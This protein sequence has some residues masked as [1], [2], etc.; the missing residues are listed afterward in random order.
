[1]ALIA[2]MFMTSAASARG[3]H[4]IGLVFDGPAPTNAQLRAA[5]EREV[6]TLAG[7]E[8][9][10]SFPKD[11]TL[12]ADWTPE[13]I[14]K[15]LDSL[16][17]DPEVTLV[18]TLG[19]QASYTATQRKDLPKVVYAGGL[20]DVGLPLPQ[21]DGRSGVKNL[22]YLVGSWS[23]TREL[24]LFQSVVPFKR[25]AIVVPEFVVSTMPQALAWGQAQTQDA[26]IELAG[27]V[28]SG[29][30]PEAVIAAL[31]A[32]IEAVYL[33]PLFQM[34]PADRKKLYDALKD[35]KLPTWSR[36]G[37]PEVERGALAGAAPQADLQRRARRIALE[38]Q[39]ML[40]GTPASEIPVRFVEGE[41]LVVNMATARAIGR[42]PSWDVLS[43][44]ELL[45]AR[46][47]KLR[48]LDLSAVMRQ[49]MQRNLDLKVADQQVA[50]GE[51]D[52]ESAKASLLPTVE[53]SALGLMIDRDRARAA[54]GNSPERYI[55]GTISLSQVLYADP[56]WGQYEIQQKLQKQR[57]QSRDQQKLDVALEAGQAF[58]NLLRARTFER[59]QK[60]N[61]RRTRKNLELAEI[62]KE[63][64]SG[65]PGE[66]Y[67]WQSEIAQVKQSALD[68]RA[69]RHLAEIEV[70]RV[71][72][73]DLEDGFEVEETTLEDPRLIISD[74]RVFQFLNDPLS[75]SIFRDFMVE[76]AVKASPELKQLDSLIEA[77]ARS[78]L[79]AERRYYMPTVALQ[80]EL[81][82]RL[83]KGGE[84]AEA[85]IT[86]P[87]DLPIDLSFPT[88][89]ETFWS[90]GV[91]VSLPLYEGGGRSAAVRKAE[92][93][94]MRLKQQRASA[95]L[96]VEQRMRAA[97]QT[98]SASYRGIQLAR[99]AAK[100]AR[101]NFDLVTDAYGRGAANVIQLVDAQNAALVADQ[102]A[103]NAI[104]DFLL[105]YLTAERAVG[106]FSHL[107][108]DAVSR[109]AWL[110]R[111]DAWFRKARA[112]KTPSSSTP[113]QQ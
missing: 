92:A 85:G 89:D 65:N 93:E 71:M 38:T 6:L 102:G 78:E 67:R 25:M 36:F 48:T 72:N 4:R 56:V 87:D 12:T 24:Q 45:N 8:F 32:D 110:D 69:G 91:N 52:V 57:R 111:A 95:K 26:G 64:G 22:A 35:R 30:D 9:E 51:E 31:P 66:V 62:R 18:I 73:H 37:R 46:R 60:E 33:A 83:A 28:P 44:A 58:L 19:F 109:K 23:M 29:T 53:V 97:L 104:F 84:G 55:D 21:K 5:V 49:A 77:Q 41:R 74:Q 108:S 106:S 13:G 7:A 63:V 86:L 79:L 68:A 34:K 20:V 75:F 11:K 17:A 99:D 16:L 10:V 98:V 70:N 39:Q 40:M 100:A 15:A 54:Q 107:E 27:I 80:A 47:P 94:L 2:V 112:P 101:Q 103:A 96:R 90:V 43:E 105:D 59:I 1:M 50:A 42:L 88:F 81:Q 61:L 3:A 76:E 113:A 14:G 82:Q